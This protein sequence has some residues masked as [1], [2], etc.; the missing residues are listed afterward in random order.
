MSLRKLEKQAKP[1]IKKTAPV[2]CH[3]EHIGN[4]EMNT[5]STFPQNLA[6]G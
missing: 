3:A 1:G 4:F 6:A 5:P 2:R